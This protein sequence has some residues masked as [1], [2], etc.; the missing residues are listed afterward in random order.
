MRNSQ[1][2][3]CQRA[4]VQSQFAV[5]PRGIVVGVAFNGRAGSI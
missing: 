1:G 3:V 2:T 5:A 4:G